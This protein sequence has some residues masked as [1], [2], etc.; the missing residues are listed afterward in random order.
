MLRGSFG[1]CGADLVVLVWRGDALSQHGPV[2]CRDRAYSELA[3]V[4][5]CKL[6]RSSLFCQHI[7]SCADCS[8][9]LY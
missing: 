8:A 6:R 4:W 2:Q 7:V 3:P 9:M 5:H 1:Q